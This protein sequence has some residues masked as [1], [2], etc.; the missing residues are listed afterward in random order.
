MSNTIK[1]RPD[2][3]QKVMRKYFEQYPDTAFEVAQKEAKSAARKGASEL[4]NISPVKTGRYA[5]GW[6]HKALRQSVM[7]YTDIIYNRTDYQLTHLLEKP[8]KVNGGKE[9]PKSGGKDY[10]GMIAEVEEKYG[11]KF[12]NGTFESLH[13]MWRAV[14]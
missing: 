13:K 2:E 6:S 7:G 12:Y 10:T 11:T 1:A 4:K 9:Y 3:F 5:R 14:K 8:H